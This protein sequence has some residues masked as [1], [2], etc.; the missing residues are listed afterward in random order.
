[1]TQNEIKT[2]RHILEKCQE[3]AVALY[4]YIA[5]HTNLCAQTK[6]A[7]DRDEKITHRPVPV[8]NRGGAI[9]VRI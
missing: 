9:V 7:T 4:S 6:M 8:D 3:C 5:I 2:N 1:M